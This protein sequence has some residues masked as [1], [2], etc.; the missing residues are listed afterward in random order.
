MTRRRRRR[1][2]WAQRGTWLLIGLCIGT[3][4]HRCDTTPPSLDP[5]TEGTTPTTRRPTALTS[6][7]DTHGR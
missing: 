4:L 3:Q 2:I 1:P 5:C 7:E 6:E